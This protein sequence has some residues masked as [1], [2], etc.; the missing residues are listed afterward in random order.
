MAIAVLTAGRAEEANRSLTSPWKL[1]GYF[2][3]AA[4]PHLGHRKIRS[5]RLGF[6]T[7]VPSA[8]TGSPFAWSPSEVRLNP[9]SAPLL[10]RS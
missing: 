10:R 8:R 7:K 9:R 2:L 6:A 4:V 5:Q 3:A 1:I